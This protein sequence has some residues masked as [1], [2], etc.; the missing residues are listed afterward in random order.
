MKLTWCHCRKKSWDG[1]ESN[2]TRMDGPVG[3][4]SE[5]ESTGELDM[6]VGGELDG[7]TWSWR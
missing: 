5:S 4:L 7:S 2:G 6:V 3:S 1:N